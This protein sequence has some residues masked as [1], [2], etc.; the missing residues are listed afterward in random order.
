MTTNPATLTDH[1]ARDGTGGFQAG[2]LVRVRDDVRPP[3]YAGR[4]ATVV[5]VRRTVPRAIS[6]AL[7][8]DG[9]TTSNGDFEIGVDFSSP[10][11]VGEHR[12][13]SWFLP[14]E[15][16]PVDGA[17][18]RSKAPRSHA[19][20][21]S[22]KQGPGGGRVSTT[23]EIAT[24]GLVGKLASDV[25]LR[26]SQAGKAYAK[27]R[28]VVETPKVAGDWRGEKEST[29]YD[30]IAFGSLAENA[31][32]SLRKGDRVVVTGRAETEEWTARDG[33]HRTTNKL[34]ATAVGADLRFVTASLARNPRSSAPSD[35]RTDDPPF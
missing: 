12:T 30:V 25:E 22:A 14:R 28:I 20:S 11:A 26:Y 9:K 13:D 7:H 33:S 5:E 19:K 31:A 18:G 6:D 15:L 32:E 29:Y 3:Q 2:Q 21:R 27:A 17:P 8:R 24:V 1:T 35:V 16:T 34:V 4:T 10:D 23:T